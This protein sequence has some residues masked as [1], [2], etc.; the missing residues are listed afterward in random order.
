VVIGVLATTGM[1][2]GEVLALD[3]GDVD[4]R[5]GVI[6]VDASKFSRGR[7]VPVAPST[8]AALDHYRR[9]RPRPGSGTALFVHT[10]GGRLGYGSFARAFAWAL[11]IAGISSVPQRPRIHDLRHSFAVA[12]VL[13][14]YREGADVA[15]LLPRLSTYLGHTGPAATYWYL[16]A[17]PELM[18]IVAERLEPGDGGGR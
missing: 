6:T 10:R 7:H 13:G 16:S 14:W 17:A 4:W 15:A 9:A 2:I 1:R 11:D 5:S 12:T 3:V 8:L 18:A